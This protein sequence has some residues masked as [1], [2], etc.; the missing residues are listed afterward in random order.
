MQFNS[1]EF[2]VFFLVVYG[3]YLAMRRN[4]RAQN[5]LLLVGSYYFYGSWDPRFL[6]LLVI[7]TVIDYFVGLKLAVT[8]DNRARRRLLVLSLASNLGMLAVFKYFNFF[9][10]S[11]VALLDSFGV[12]ANA[13]DL[14][15]VLPVGIS[16]YTFQTLSYTIDIYRRRLEPTKNFLNFALFVSF[17][18]QL[19]AGPIERASHLLPQVEKPRS[20]QT[21][22]INAGLFLILWG[23]YK[24]VV[25]ADN[26]AGIANT[27]YNGYTGYHGLDLVLGTLAFAFQIYCDFSAYS[28]IARGISKLM[29]FDLMINFRLPYFAASPSDFWQRWH[30]SL[31]TW[32]RDYLYIP[33]GGNR[34]SDLK[35]LRNLMVTMLLGGLWHGASWTF[36]IW[37]AFH[38]TILIVYRL[39]E[40]RAGR[41][42]KMPS[43]TLSRTW[44]GL[45]IAFM[46]FLTL[47]GWVFFRARSIPQLVHFLTES[48][49]AIS[50]ATAGFAYEIAFFALPL[51]AVQVCQQK[52][53][54]LLV[55]AKLPMIPRLL[56]YGFLLLSIFV[57]GVRES[58]EFIYFQ[59]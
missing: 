25:V 31:S 43:T 8:E 26:M 22:E 24:K 55:P 51:V 7:S 46:F 47:I 20:L 23:Y 11:F 57:L 2:V 4:I 35:T 52:S 44:L 54:D 50:T 15:I 59:F 49:L 1:F 38:G 30:I 37:G 9:Q 45:R 40:T 34:L 29:G 3:L 28:D 36:V 10:D 56:F 42:H 53:G 13:I 18:P 6:S 48:G 21:R 39:F 19:V 32:L 33:L 5:F 58:V 17:F 41:Q 14:H 27:I 12:Q 16:F